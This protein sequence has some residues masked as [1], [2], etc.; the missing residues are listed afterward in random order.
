[1]LDPRSVGDDEDVGL[2]AD[3]DL[4]ADAVE[5]FALEVGV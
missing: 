5:V 4:V 2:F 3:A 1:M